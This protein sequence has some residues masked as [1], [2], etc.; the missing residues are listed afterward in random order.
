MNMTVL[1]YETLLRRNPDLAGPALPESRRG[2]GAAPEEHEEQ[3]A[4]IRWA[5]E[6]EA[7]WPE[8]RWLFHVPNGGYRDPATAALLATQ[9]IRAGVPDLLLL[10]PRRGADGD[11]IHG[12]AIEM[13][14]RDH[15]NS[16]SA[17]Q[18]TWLLALREQGY[19]AV[20]AYGAT[21]AVGYLE[22]YLGLERL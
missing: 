18:R 19:M 5:Q 1:Q 3:A 14:K 22:H 2:D 20:V 17:A 12:L 9:G 21:E 6:Q 8:L 16:P 10:V 15:S 7:R 13:K 11:I 4:V